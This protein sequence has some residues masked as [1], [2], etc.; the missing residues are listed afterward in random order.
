MQPHCRAYI[1]VLAQRVATFPLIWKICL[2]FPITW[3]CLTALCQVRINCVGSEVLTAVVMNLIQAQLC[4]LSASCLAYSPSLRKEVTC[5]SK[6]SVSF[7]WIT[8]HHM[9][10]NGSH[11]RI[12]LTEVFWGQPKLGFPLSPSCRSEWPFSY[13]PSHT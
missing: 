4:L 11:F 7:Q 13:Q 10:K 6:T 5:S 8:Q 1:Q 2:T 3:Y 12:K 9:P